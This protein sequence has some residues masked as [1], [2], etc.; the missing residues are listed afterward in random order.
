MKMLAEEP[1]LIKVNSSK[2]LIADSSK[3]FQESD[4]FQTLGPYWF[5]PMV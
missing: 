4:E 3:T 2:I 5:R 1:D